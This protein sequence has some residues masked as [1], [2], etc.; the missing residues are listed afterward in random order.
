MTCSRGDAVPCCDSAGALRIYGVG[1]RPAVGHMPDR[2]AGERCR[3]S[4]PYG[5]G[6]GTARTGACPLGMMMMM[7]L[8]QRFFFLILHA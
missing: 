8:L 7:E 5:S 3:V 6:V 1:A 2:T 4:R